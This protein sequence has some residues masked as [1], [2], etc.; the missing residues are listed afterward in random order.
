[1]CSI[2]SSLFF[3]HPGLTKLGTAVP[4][5]YLTPNLE[6]IC[7][8]H[9]RSP[10][11]ASRSAP[12][13]LCGSEPPPSLPPPLEALWHAGKALA[14][15]PPGV[16]RDPALH[17]IF[18]CMGGANGE[19]TP[20]PTE[21]GPEGSAPW[22][23]ARAHAIT[24]TVEYGYNPRGL[25][26]SPPNDPDLSWVHGFLHMQE[27]DEQNARGWYGRSGRAPPASM[28]MGLEAEWENI[29]ASLTQPMHALT[30]AQL[31]EFESNGCLTVD[32]GLTPA[33]LDA[34]EA[35][36]N[37][38][39]APASKRKDAK[40]HTDATRIYV[41]QTF[42]GLFGRAQFVHVTGVL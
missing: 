10:L 3:H 36:W 42:P 32:T 7:F 15:A 9:R 24:Q 40:T 31:A 41:S 1:M 8:V 37:Q 25:E 2:G 23:W 27:G 5:L 20:D 16:E 21:A 6:W 29:S 19:P 18:A 30:K 22:H 17:G 26:G 28:S 13:M 34:A 38:L 4:E 12:G 39:T 35:A 14:L 11:G 33:E